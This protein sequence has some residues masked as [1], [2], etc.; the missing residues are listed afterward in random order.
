MLNFPG[1]GSVSITPDD[2]SN[3]PRLIR[4]LYVTVGG[5]VVFVGEDG[6]QDTW[7]VSDN[8]IIP[9]RMV[10]VLATGTTATGLKGVK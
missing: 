1:S 10:K 9:I 3:L 5:D 8:F 2:S 7:T 4:S 6:V